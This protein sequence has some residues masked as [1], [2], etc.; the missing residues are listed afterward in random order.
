MKEIVAET[1]LNLNAT[2]VCRWTTTRLS[3]QPTRKCSSEVQDSDGMIDQMVISTLFL[4]QNTVGRGRSLRCSQAAAAASIQMK[5]LHQE[6]TLRKQPH[7]FMPWNTQQTFS[8]ELLTLPSS[9]NSSSYSFS[10]GLSRRHPF[11]N[12]LV[13]GCWA[14]V[15]LMALNYHFCWVETFGQESGAIV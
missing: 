2:D 13:V 11:F 4:Y 14:H 12:L 3:R 9:A 5:T 8:Y 10:T 1:F 7:E 6:L 15:K